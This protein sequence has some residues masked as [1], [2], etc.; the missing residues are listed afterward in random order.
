MSEFGSVFAKNTVVMEEI[1]KPVVGY[2]GMYEVSNLGNIKSLNYN[3][4]RE[5]RVMKPTDFGGGYL[6]VK[7]WKNKTPKLFFVHRLVAQAFIPNP[8]NLPEI[9]HKDENPSNNRVENLEWCDRKY[10]INYGTRTEKYIRTNTNG[11]KSKQVVQYS[12][13]GEAIKVWPSTSEIQRQLGFRSGNIS[14][15]CKGRQKT[16]YGFI[17]QYPVLFINVV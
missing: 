2:E 15:C 9:N 14:N 13:D 4:T 17:W 3:G 6:R 12:L 10:N 11:K 7:L 8:D 1:W 5:K 16:A